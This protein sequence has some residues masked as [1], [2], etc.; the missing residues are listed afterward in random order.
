MPQVSPDQLGRLY[1]NE[2]ELKIGALLDFD[3]LL[4]RTVSTFYPHNLQFMR[5]FN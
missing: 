5:V 3:Y 4:N 1:V 2:A